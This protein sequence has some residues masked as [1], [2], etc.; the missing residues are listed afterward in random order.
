MIGFL[1]F[2]VVFQLSKDWQTESS[3]AGLVTDALY[4]GSNRIKH[5]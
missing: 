2:Y 4:Q 1:P 3:H 5:L